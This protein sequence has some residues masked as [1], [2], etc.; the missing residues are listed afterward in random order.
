M[1]SPAQ[2]DERSIMVGV[3]LPVQEAGLDTSQPSGH[4]ESAP[5]VKVSSHVPLPGGVNAAVSGEEF[6]IQLRPST[7]L[8]QISPGLLLPALV[9][10]SQP[11]LVH[12]PQIQ[13][14]SVVGHSA[15][16]G[17]GVGS[18]VTV[19]LVGDDVG[20]LPPP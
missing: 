10:Y 15:V 11:V 18:G 16:E 3:E 20:A 13:G 12:V 14:S 8:K 9:E 5:N 19:D 1:T 17:A 4:E 7:A 6:V 2:D